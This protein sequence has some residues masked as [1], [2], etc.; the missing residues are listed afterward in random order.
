MND[1]PEVYLES[2]GPR[3]ENPT[4]F[5]DGSHWIK[6]PVALRIGKGRN[7]VTVWVN[8]NMEYPDLD[9]LTDS[10]RSESDSDSEWCPE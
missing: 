8:P 4:L 6:V 2:N 9:S 5:C 3:D 10:G 7:A 1:E